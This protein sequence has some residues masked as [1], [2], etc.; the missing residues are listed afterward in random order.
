MKIFSKLAALIL[1]TTSLS[2][3]SLNAQT[4]V[5]TLPDFNFYTLDNKPFLTR[6]VTPGK[7]SLFVFFDAN[8]DHCQR[9]VSALGKRSSD[10]KAIGVY[11]VSLDSKEVINQ[12]MASYGKNLKG[13]KNVQVLQDLKYQFIPKFQPK[14]YPALFLYSPQRKLIM[15]T[16]DEKEVDRVVAA[17]M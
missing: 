14:K 9:A 13:M 15:Y 12:F 4:P 11:M 1:I 2:S 7:K 6:N 5:A 16:N 3:L 17:A 10:L 8:C